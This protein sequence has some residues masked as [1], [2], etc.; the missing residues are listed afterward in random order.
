MFFTGAV[1][2]GNAIV[3]GCEHAQRWPETIDIRVAKIAMALL[4]ILGAELMASVVIE[5]YRPRVP[6]EQERPIIESRLLA[7]FT[8][9]GGVARNFATTLDY[10]FGFSVSEARFYRFLE[11]IL[12]PAVVLLALLLWLQTCLVVIA[13][14][15]NG[16][17]EH[18]G[19]V[20]PEPLQPGLY[21]KFPSPF[22]KIYRY[23]VHEIQEIALGYADDATE[24]EDD[25]HGHEA[26]NNDDDSE[27]RIIVWSQSHRQEETKYIVASRAASTPQQETGADAPVAAYSLAATV[28]IY[29][30]VKDLYDFKYRHQDG[31]ETLTRLAAREVFHYLSTVDFFAILTSGREE[32]TAYLAQRIQTEA[33]KLQLGIQIVSVGLQGLHPPVEVG[34]SFDDVVAA[35]EERETRILQAETYHTETVVG[36]R[37]EEAVLLNEA[38]AYRLDKVQNSA[39][40]A[41]RFANQLLGYRQSPQLFVLNSLLDVL[42]NEGAE[43]RKYIVAAESGRRV[44][45]L[46][47]I[48]KG[49]SGLLSGD[50]PQK[51]ENADQ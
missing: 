30:R 13:T 27:H 42:E 23:P 5:F 36:S 44:F 37:G 14:E 40:T 22:E 51:A 41:A 16:L 46:D 50:I 9:P 29:F 4:I 20:D 1:F 32:G 18:F 8:E 49:T 6:G 39:A 25:G 10:Q 34:A 35:T 28:P 45:T 24:P 19:H 3:M 31:K 38:E 33:D 47:L 15:E 26:E 12:V 11:R 7:L 43:T 21:I 48:E 2:F 17:R